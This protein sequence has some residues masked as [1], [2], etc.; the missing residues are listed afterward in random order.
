MNIPINDE[1][2]E[3]LSRVFKQAW[4]KANDAGLEGSRTTAGITAVLSEINHQM[5]RES[6]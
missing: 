6:Q 5:T 1:V 2:V 3:G 4:H